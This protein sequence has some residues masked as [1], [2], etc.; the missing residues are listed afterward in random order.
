M[1]PRVPVDEDGTHVSVIHNHARKGLAIYD[2]SQV[3]HTL[4][5]FHWKFI[6]ELKDPALGLVGY[7]VGIKVQF[8]FSLV[9]QP[10]KSSS[11]SSRFFQLAR[12][13]T[14]SLSSRIF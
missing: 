9:L 12:W 8:H 7:H 2:K 13:S 4:S 11:F 3:L 10:L 5:N 6:S 1:A 14:S